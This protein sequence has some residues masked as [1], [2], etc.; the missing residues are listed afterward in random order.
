MLSFITNAVYDFVRQCF[1]KNSHIN[2]KK[3]IQVYKAA[4]ESENDLLLVTDMYVRLE[5]ES[6]KGKWNKNNIYYLD[7]LDGLTWFKQHGN[8]SAKKLAKKGL[9]EYFYS[10]SHIESLSTEQKIQ[11]NVTSRGY[12]K[13]SLLALAV[14]NALAQKEIANASEISESKTPSNKSKQK[15]PSAEIKTPAEE[16]KP[17]KKAAKP[18]KPIK[19]PIVETVEEEKE[20]PVVQ[21]DSTA[22]P[23]YSAP[24]YKNKKDKKPKI[25][26]HLLK[27]LE[28]AAAEKTATPESSEEKTEN[29]LQKEMKH[30]ETKKE[31][32]VPLKEVAMPKALP[33]A[34]IKL[35][36]PIPLGLIQFAHKLKELTN[37]DV[38]LGGSSVTGMRP[39]RDGDLRLF[40]NK[41]FFSLESL[42]RKLLSWKEIVKC[43]IITHTAYPIIQ[44]VLQYGSHKQKIELAIWDKKENETTDEAMIRILN[45]KSD[46]N[47]S[48]LYIPLTGKLEI[49][50]SQESIDSFQAQTLDV[51]NYQHRQKVFLEDPVRLLRLVVKKADHPEFNYGNGLTE[52]L[53]RYSPESCFRSRLTE[54]L[55]QKRLVTFLQKTLFNRFK[56][57]GAMHLMH[58]NF[59]IFTALTGIPF[60]DKLQNTLPVLE[61]YDDANDYARL[62]A[63]FVFAAV[64]FRLHLPENLKARADK[65]YEWQLKWIM[66][67]KLYG[68]HVHAAIERM[69]KENLNFNDENFNEKFSN[70]I[71][72]VP[73]DL[74][75]TTNVHHED[76]EQKFC[77]LPTAP[78]AKEDNTLKK[79]PL[80]KGHVLFYTTSS[81]NYHLPQSRAAH[82]R[83]LFNTNQ[84]TH[85]PHSFLTFRKKG[86]VASASACSQKKEIVTK[87]FY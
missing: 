74:R 43:K 38:F 66:D 41:K 27:A 51:V 87:R 30:T 24:V 31:E 58:D 44:A 16:K 52:I 2:S 85:N 46:L 17:I 25:S 22:E 83:R 54:K 20:S 53:Q 37:Q 73:K 79:K 56:L 49:R 6:I 23:T 86:A 76:K 69:V 80:Q 63:F 1:K 32:V 21:A 48:S 45:T 64:Q 28:K 7:L 11:R 9:N 75:P 67:S 15:S 81:A 82:K 61:H 55:E 36:D 14:K 62:V 47:V 29:V 59:N 71:K 35:K 68:P 60:D 34:T 8:Q 78:V 57:V 50:G 10:P 42:Y 70:I 5:Q 18:P 33:Y 26:P 65:L 84:A 3:R 40:G 12:L 13:L 72:M 4:V 19:T 39:G 77:S